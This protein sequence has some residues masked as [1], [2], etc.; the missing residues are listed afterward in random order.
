MAKEQKPPDAAA[1]AAKAL[2]AK[3]GKAFVQSIT[4][5]IG[6]DKDHGWGIDDSCEVIETLIAEDG[7]DGYAP[8]EALM[9]YIKRVVNPSQFRQQLE[10]AEQLNKSV[11]AEKRKAGLDSL[12]KSFG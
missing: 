6:G 12:L 8:S 7:P 11:K 3:L 1:E 9:S 2:D 4:S 10:S 5:A